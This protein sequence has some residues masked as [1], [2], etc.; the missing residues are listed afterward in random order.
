MNAAIQNPTIFG[1]LE[2][3]VGHDELCRSGQADNIA[4]RVLIGWDAS[5]SLLSIDPPGEGVWRAPH[6]L[7][8]HDLSAGASLVAILHARMSVDEIEAGLWRLLRILPDAKKWR[9]QGVHGI[10]PQDPFLPDRDLLECQTRGSFVRSLLF[11]APRDAADFLW[12]KLRSDPEIGRCLLAKDFKGA[13]KLDPCLWDVDWPHVV[14]A[15]FK[16]LGHRDLIRPL[17]FLVALA[18]LSRLARNVGAHILLSHRDD[19]KPMHIATYNYAFLATANGAAQA[20]TRRLAG[21]AALQT[22]AMLPPD[23][24]Y[25]E[26]DGNLGQAWSAAVALVI[27]EA[28]AAEKE[29]AFIPL[30]QP[31][32]L[33]DARFVRDGLLAHPALAP[34]NGPDQKHAFRQAHFVTVRGLSPKA[35]SMTGAFQIREQVERWRSGLAGNSNPKTLRKSDSEGRPFSLQQAAAALYYL[36]LETSRPEALSREMNSITGQPNFDGSN[37]SAPP[38]SIDD[39]A[40]D[41]RFGESLAKEVRTAMAALSKPGVPGYTAWYR[42]HLWVCDEGDDINYYQK[43][44]QTAVRNWDLAARTGIILSDDALCKVPPEIVARMDLGKKM[45]SARK[46]RRLAMRSHRLSKDAIAARY[47]QRSVMMVSAASTDQMWRLLLSR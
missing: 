23:V 24:V 3:I 20:R 45:S 37:P 11:A 12:A 2:Q 17:A 47:A 6:P 18:C 36:W 5:R 27:A 22:T 7:V 35:H 19:G 4:E 30:T 38:D 16:L 8:M 1:E 10:A 28:I 46:A 39:L 40:C 43:L 31:P 15:R 33:I 9:R 42:P 41:K 26:C 29:K 14:K 21:Y 13:L 25:D 44:Q 34:N 32:S